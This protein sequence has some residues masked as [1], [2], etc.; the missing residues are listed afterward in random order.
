VFYDNSRKSVECYANPF[1]VAIKSKAY[2]IRESE[3]KKKGCWN[4]YKGEHDT[5]DSI[6]EL[7]EKNLL[8]ENQAL[9]ELLLWMIYNGLI[10]QKTKLYT[11][12]ANNLQL[13]NNLKILS[14]QFNEFYGYKKIPDLDHKPFSKK[15][16]TIKWLIAVNT[17]PQLNESRGLPSDF[18]EDI[19]TPVVRPLFSEKKPIT[20]KLKKT[21][22]LDNDTSVSKVLQQF[23]GDKNINEEPT[24]VVS[25]IED[26]NAKGNE[27]VK[28]LPPS[29]D[30]L[31]AWSHSECL[32]RDCIVFE[33][34]SWGE[35]TAH[36]YSGKGWLVRLFVKV[37]NGIQQDFKGVAEMLDICM[38]QDFY[39][40]NR[41]KSRIRNLMHS[42]IEFFFP[43][44][45]MV[46][47]EKDN[48]KVFLIRI[49]GV[50]YCVSR[51]E[52][53]YNWFETDNYQKVFLKNNL[54]YSKK[55]SYCF[56]KGSSLGRFYQKAVESSQSNRV[57]IFFQ[58]TN[59]KVNYITVDKNGKLSVSESTR[60]EMRLYLPKFVYSISLCMKRVE[61]LYNEKYDAKNEN[62][63]SIAWYKKDKNIEK[64]VNITKDTMSI[65]P[66]AVKRL[67]GIEISLKWS[68]YKSLL[69]HYI[70][71][72]RF[73]FESEEG[74]AAFTHLVEN[75]KKLRKGSRDNDR[76]HY[77]IILTDI[78]V[79]LDS[80]ENIPMSTSVWLNIK[81]TIEIG[82]AHQ[83]EIKIE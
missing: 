78:Q 43:E 8:R 41:F 73:L 12:L 35:I 40:P 24:T 45:K 31:N 7:E 44:G 75:F 77:P 63:I 49:H 82:I 72:G 79:V 20:G 46:A 3:S 55:I 64:M 76:D 15:P 61:Q 19:E 66:K 33:Q 60:E 47:Y 38:G 57:D 37:L 9:S 29:E 34:N 25:E 32:L 56:D 1:R 58:K 23:K 36:E 22:T 54:T 6:G 67:T 21:K 30:P 51:D 10:D 14:H 18:E 80:E 5:H 59:K 17:Y 70:S 83:L 81:S 62:A 48:V 16:K 39:D 2:T 71:D 50:C 65:V 53:K 27:S 68:D 13:S 74:G 69:N 52:S 4:L 11:S 26:E 42:M 28:I